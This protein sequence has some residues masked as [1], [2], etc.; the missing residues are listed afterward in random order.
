M[1]DA[2]KLEEL[3]ETIQELHDN[4]LEKPDFVLVTKFL[5]NLMVVMDNQGQK[6][7]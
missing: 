1:S 3:R 4:N 6:T 2:E 5:L 7:D